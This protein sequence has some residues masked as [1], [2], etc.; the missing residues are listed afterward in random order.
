MSIPGR[1]PVY[2]CSCEGCDTKRYV[3]H[4]Q[5]DGRWTIKQIGLCEHGPNSSYLEGTSLFLLKDLLQGNCPHRA[6]A[7]M[8]EAFLDDPVVGKMSAKWIANWNARRA[9]P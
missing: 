7:L 3:R 5:V 2:A 8:R 1:Q 9:A 4:D 6:L